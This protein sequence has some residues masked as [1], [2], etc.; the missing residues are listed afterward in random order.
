MATN[1]KPTKIQVDIFNYW[2]F[3]PKYDSKENLTGTSISFWMEHPILGVANF[4][5]HTCGTEENPFSCGFLR[6]FTIQLFSDM[7]L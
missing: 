5:P 1:I 2:M 4:D 7:S 3:H 6:V